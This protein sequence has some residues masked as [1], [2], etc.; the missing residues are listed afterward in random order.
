VVEGEPIE[1]V[2][3]VPREALDLSGDTALAAL[4]DGPWVEVGLG[5]CD[6]RHCVVLDGL[7]EGSRLRRPR[8]LR[9]PGKG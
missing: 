9:D 6:A 5:S 8:I 4:A 1:D 2:L 7:E 3:L